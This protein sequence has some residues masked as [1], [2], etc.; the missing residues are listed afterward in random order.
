MIYRQFFASMGIMVAGAFIFCM[1]AGAFIIRIIGA[2]FGLMLVHI[3]LRSLGFT[4]RS[5]RFYSDSW[6]YNIRR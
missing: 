5:Y 3:G 1:F 2:L 4:S 6:F